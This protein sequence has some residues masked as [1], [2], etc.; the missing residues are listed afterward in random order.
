MGRKPVIELAGETFG[1]WTVLRRSGNASSG[2]AKW[3]CRCCCGTLREIPGSSLRRGDTRSCGCQ[4]R[5]RLGQHRRTHGQSS[6]LIYKLWKGMH[7]RQKAIM[8]G[9]RKDQ[10]FEICPEWIAFESFEKWAHSSGYKPGCRLVRQD[11][12]KAFNPDNCSWRE[13]RQFEV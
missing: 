12:G 13:P 1:R 3:L 4:D 11:R 6:A 10:P 9:D 2:D 5:G 7:S 8:R